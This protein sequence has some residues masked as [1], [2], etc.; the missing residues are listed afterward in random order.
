MKYEFLT[1]YV[2]SNKSRA[3]VKKVCDLQLSF[4]LKPI[5]RPRTIFFVLEVSHNIEQKPH[6]HDTTAGISIAAFV[7]VV[8][9]SLAYYQ[10][11]YVPEANAKPTFTTSITT[12]MQ[13]TEV[14][15]VKDAL[16]Q[17]SKDHFKPTDVRAVLGISN[18]VEWTNN[19]SVAHTVTGDDPQYE[20]VVNGKF[21][22]LAHPAQTG[23][24]NGF[25]EPSG[26]KWS[27]TFTKMG[28]FA[29]HCSPHPWMKGEV[30]VV[31]NFS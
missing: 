5:C 14:T 13:T 31:E 7:V 4:G 28:E 19:D 23:G 3:Q 6:D 26:G 29:Y 12:P 9:V 20:D 10:F 15:I 21:D 11:M 27:F 18:R 16:L 1:N 24:A 2:Y 30:A 8:V 22:S 25:L 17:S